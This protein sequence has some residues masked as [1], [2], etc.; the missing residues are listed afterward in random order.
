[1]LDLSHNQITGL[2]F[3]QRPENRI[4]KLKALSAVESFLPLRVLILANNQVRSIGRDTFV[5]TPHLQV[6]SLAHNL[7]ANIENDT[8]AGLQKLQYL[9]LGGNQLNRSSIRAL[10]GIP[11]LIGLSLARNPHLGDAALQGFVA[12]WSLKELDISAT[13]LCHIPAAL[14]QSVRT[15]NL[16]HNHFEVR[17]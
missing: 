3:L 2:T 5:D 10:Q 15:L 12:S 13:G 16:A 9:D 11:D 8:F 17:T 14:A 1:M 6:L 7:V 4:G